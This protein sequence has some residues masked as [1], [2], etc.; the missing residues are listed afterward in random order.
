MIPKSVP[1]RILCTGRTGGDFS[2]FRYAELLSPLSDLQA[3]NS[4]PTPLRQVFSL[5]RQHDCDLLVEEELDPTTVLGCQEEIQVLQEK[6]RPGLNPLT[7]KVI[8]VTFFRLIANNVDRLKCYTSDIDLATKNAAKHFKEFSATAGAFECLG[9]LLLY[10]DSFKGLGLSSYVPEA[11]IKPFPPDSRGP[12]IHSGGKYEAH[13]SGVRFEIDGSYFAQQ[14]GA[15]WCCAHAALMVV[16]KNVFTARGQ[17]YGTT[18]E[19]IN[20]LLNIDHQYRF[21][22]TGLKVPEIVDVLAGEGIYSDVINCNTKFPGLPGCG[23]PH[24]AD[25]VIATAYYAIEAGLPAIICFGS[26]LGHAMGVVGH[27]FEPSLWSPRASSVYFG[28]QAKPYIPSHAWVD[29]FVVQDDNF[30]PYCVLPKSVLRTQNPAVIIPRYPRSVVLTP[31]IVEWAAADFLTI[32]KYNGKSYFQTI[33]QSPSCPPRSDDSNYWFYKLMEAASRGLH[34]LRTIPISPDEYLEFLKGTEGAGDV[35]GPLTSDHINA[36]A[37]HLGGTF[38]WLV[39]I[40]IPELYQRNTRRLG[41]VFL[42][43][44]A[45]SPGNVAGLSIRIPGVLS[46]IKDNGCGFGHFEIPFKEHFPITQRDIGGGMV[47]W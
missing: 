44:D 13:V 26:D 11:V 25:R 36:I 38:T 21:A 45:G 34:V 17:S 35:L 40:S 2:F 14:E 30:G 5:M 20:Q 37:Q 24:H 32:K 15:T 46:L 3:N 19:Q 43:E 28:G 27:T 23:T 39:E 33:L 9:Y 4:A 10:I 47:F 7:R 1:S 31:E 42:Q 41:E 22:H 29:N 6:I 12:Y 16:L 8:R 18:Y